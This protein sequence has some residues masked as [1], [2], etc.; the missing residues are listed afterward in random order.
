MLTMVIRKSI[1][2]ELKISFNNQYQIIG[3]FAFS[4]SVAEQKK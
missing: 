2:E 4:L 3:D 1:L